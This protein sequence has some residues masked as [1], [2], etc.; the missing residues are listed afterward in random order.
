MS[1]YDTLEVSRKASAET[2]RAAYKSLM[3]RY[4]PDRNLGDAE[5]AVRAVS[6]QQAFEVLSDT[7]KRAVYDLGLEKMPMHDS[8]SAAQ[9]SPRPIPE[10][11]TAM[12][13]PAVIGVAVILTVG[14][15]AGYLMRDTPQPAR[16]VM[17]LSN[18]P[19]A[20]QIPSRMIDLI[21]EVEVIPLLKDDGFRTFT[22]HTLAIP[23]LKIFLGNEELARSRE[24]ILIHRDD[25]RQQ[26]RDALSQISY[27]TL[28]KDTSEEYIK[29][30]VKE[31]LNEH[32]RLTSAISPLSG[33]TPVPLLGSVERVTLPDSFEV[34]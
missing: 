3:Q 7:N 4:H 5:A 28:L 24:F 8:Q 12:F 1:H 13:T 31:V 18:E 21:D 10:S 14:V 30:R 34:K 19:S 11:E 2:I 15:I 29:A 27:E 20:P 16:A 22:G 26:L 23:R 25:L 6:I 32:I 17:P 33:V 9:L